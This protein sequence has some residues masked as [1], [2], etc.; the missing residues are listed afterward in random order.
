MPFDLELGS[1][2]AAFSLDVR[3]AFKNHVHPEHLVLKV[4]MGGG[5]CELD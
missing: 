3:G 1:S 5:L 4:P 2:T